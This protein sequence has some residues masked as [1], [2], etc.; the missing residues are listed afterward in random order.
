MWEKV[1][2]AKGI[3]GAKDQSYKSTYLYEEHMWTP[4]WL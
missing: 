3:A 4:L 1:L 2:Q